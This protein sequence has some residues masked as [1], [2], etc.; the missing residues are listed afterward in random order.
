MDDESHIHYCT[1]TDCDS[2]ETADHVWNNGEVTAEPTCATEGVKT[3]TCTDC[4]ETYTEAV[5][6]TGNHTYGKWQKLDDESHIHYCT[7][8]ECKASETAD[9][10]WNGGKITIEPTCSINGQKT[11]LCLD[12]NETKVETVPATGNHTYGDWQ[13]LNDNEHIRYCT[14][15]ECTEFETEVHKYSS[16]FDINCD[17]CEHERATSGNF[18]NDMSWQVTDDGV[19]TIEGNGDLAA[20]DT[21]PWNEYLDSITSVVISEEVTSLDSDMLDDMTNL[22]S[23]TILAEDLEI[24]DS[25]STIPSSATIYGYAGSTSEAYAEKYGREFVDISIVLGD[26]DGNDTVDNNDAI[27]LLYH[28]IF[29]EEEYPVNQECDFND[30][31]IVDNNDAIY[32]LYHT[33]FGD[34][35][36]LS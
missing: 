8:D 18:G 35:Y 12:C 36:P 16:A 3:F 1:G 17:V 29:G 6:A 19:L 27:Y 4:G 7:S 28:T 22:S 32:L 15:D 13:K 25:S 5:P 9:H 21:I 34:E 10:E 23:V 26:I 2:S 11:Y 14:G 33:I 24:E 20:S 30:D 31:G